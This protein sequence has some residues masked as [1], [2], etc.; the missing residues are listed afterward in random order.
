ME[1]SVLKQTKVKLP[2]RVLGDFGG[3]RKIFERRI[4]LS[5][6]NPLDRRSSEDRRSGFDRRS[7][8]MAPINETEKRKSFHSLPLL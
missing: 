1:F 6:F 3:R 8:L 5:V 4:D 2:P 7:T